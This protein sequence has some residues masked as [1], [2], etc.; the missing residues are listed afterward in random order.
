MAAITLRT[1]GYY[2]E[3]N[4]NSLNNALF[5]GWYSKNGLLFLECT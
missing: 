3:N 1:Q 5:S 2:L 4:L